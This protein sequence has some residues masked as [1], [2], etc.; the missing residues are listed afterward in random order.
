MTTDGPIE[1]LHYFDHQFLREADFSDEQAYH[2]RM[3]RLHNSSLHTWGIA[4]GLLPSASVNDAGVTISPGSAIDSQGREIVLA[5]AGTVDVSGLAGAARRVFI[6]IAYREQQDV[7]ATDPG[8][9]GFTRWREVPLLEVREALPGDPSLTLVLGSVEVA[10]GRVTAAPTTG[11]RRNAG[12][13]AG[14]LTANSLQANRA[15]VNG[16][17]AVTGNI[18]VTGRVDGR[19]VSAD[20]T[21][22]DNHTGSRAN[23]HVTTAAQ[24]GALA[25]S[26]GT[27]L[28]QVVVRTNGPPPTQPTMIVT[29]QPNQQAGI[30]TIVAALSAVSAHDTVPGLY[31]R[32][33]AFSNPPTT[34][35]AAALRVDGTTVLT[36]NGGTVPAPV[37]G[38]ALRIEGN[39][40]INGTLTVPSG[41][42]GY[43]IDTFV[44]AS[45]ARLQ[46][47]D[48]VRLKGTPIARFYGVNN[49]IP[50]AEVTLADQEHASMVIGIVDQEALPSGEGPDTRT[51]PDDPTFVAEGGDLFVVTLGTYAHCKVDAAGGPIAVGDLLTP[52]PNPGFAQRASEPRLGTIIGKALE[53]LAEGT[54]YIAVFVNCQ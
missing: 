27:V 45:G 9:T 10:A 16:D 13:V 35:S 4:G 6:T 15:A 44:N 37:A 33:H 48:V 43:V 17:L 18:A 2:I 38:E 14:D 30:N 24:V 29:A 8:V 46:T 41:K 47:G 42:G 5:E 52:S 34:S 31:V 20:G 39:V 32:S 53:P 36:R 25:S 54:G 11:D 21:A 19:D 22:L 12:V 49:K 40:H 50:V 26:G 51:D 7:A 3:R 28:G 1:R 23:P